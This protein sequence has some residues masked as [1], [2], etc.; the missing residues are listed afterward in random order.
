[1]QASKATSLVFGP[2]SFAIESNTRT[3]RLML[4]L[5]AESDILLSY[6][7]KDNSASSD[8]SSYMMPKN[9]IKTRLL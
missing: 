2:Y 1:V 8:N 4:L 7:C 3:V 5:A 6:S 9:T